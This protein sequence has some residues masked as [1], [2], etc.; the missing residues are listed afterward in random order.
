MALATLIEHKKISFI[1]SQNVDGLFLKTGI[2]RKFISELH[3]N[4]FLDECNVCKS[5]FVRSSC[6]DTMGLKVSEVPCPRSSRPCRGFLRDTILDWEDELPS[7]EL[8]KAALM[9]QKADLCICL[10]TSLQIVPAAN[11]PFL[12]KKN[13]G[14]VC[15]IN[16]QKTKFDTKADL[17][18]HENLDDVF[19][20]LIKIL[21]LEVNKYD[22]LKDLTKAASQS[23]CTWK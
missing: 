13:G 1:V 11:L 19:L 12:C 3:G 21:G 20:H 5:R 18:I 4:F 6:S 16:L 15:I 2:R 22:P 7:S 8:R 17:V 23:Q 9:S 10:G 14:R